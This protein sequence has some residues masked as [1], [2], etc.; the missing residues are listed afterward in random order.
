[1]TLPAVFV[2]PGF[3]VVASEVVDG[4]L[5]LLVETPRE[6]VG[7]PVCGAVAR[8]KDRRTVTVRDL[9]AGGMPVIIRWRK[10]VFECRYALCEKKTWTEQHEAIA[11]R[12]V[13]TERARQWAFEQVGFHDRAVSAVAGQLGVAWHT[14]MTQVISRGQPLV[15]DPDRLAGV[16]AIGVDETAFLRATGT[17]PDAVRH[18][19]RR[20][21]RRAG[22]RGCW[23]SS[24]AG[25]APSWATGSTGRDEAWRA[26]DRDRVVG[27]VPRLRHRP[28]HAPTRR[29]PGA[30]PVP[31]G[32]TR[33]AGGGPGPPPGAAGH[34]RAP[35]PGRRPAVPGPA[36]PA[37]PPR[38]AHRP[39]IGPAA[40]RADRRRPERGDHRRLARRAD[41]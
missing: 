26:A 7:C 34:H 20:P 23:T 8:V 2:L 6:L 21:D 36:D 31:P 3:R 1:M 12:A 22:H 11:P 16:S 24:R 25:P 41:A 35:R 14:I 4:E 9:P 39:A 29:G 32:Q 27:P 10:R 17:A 33:A 40:G 15:D 38:P 30:G 28:D 18:R 13:L 5:D 19:D 37:P